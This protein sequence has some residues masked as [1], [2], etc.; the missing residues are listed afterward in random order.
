MRILKRSRKREILIPYKK[1]K[2]PEKFSGGNVRKTDGR[3]KAAGKSYCGTPAGEK[4]GREPG[5][6]RDKDIENIYENRVVEKTA[7]YNGQEGESDNVYRK[8]NGSF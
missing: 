3:E 2:Q 5:K 7:D 6:N 1:R 4:T 8:S